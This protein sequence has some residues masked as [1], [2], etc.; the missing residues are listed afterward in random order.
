LRTRPFPGLCPASRA[1][2]AKEKQAGAGLHR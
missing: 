1:V 2:S